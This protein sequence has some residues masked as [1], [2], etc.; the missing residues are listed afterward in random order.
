MP[1]EKLLQRPIYGGVF[2]ED[3][4]YALASVPCVS[5]GLHATRY[6]VVQPQAGIVLSVSEDKVQALSVARERLNAAND[7]RTTRAPTGDQ[8]ELFPHEPLLTLSTAPP[9]VHIPRRRREVF[10]QSRG[11]CHYCAAVLTLDG[12]WHVEHQL[13]R[14][15]GGDDTGLNLVAACVPCNLAKSDRTAIEFVALKS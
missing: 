7:N 6:M 12:K 10:A 4:R 9:L 1:A 15:L 5:H 3:G 11:R 2:G 8:G 13:P 14:A